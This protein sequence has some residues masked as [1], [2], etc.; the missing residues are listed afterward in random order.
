MFLVV[1]EKERQLAQ[2][3]YSIKWNK[4]RNTCL[5]TMSLWGPYVQ[6]TSRRLKLQ[7]YEHRQ[8]KANYTQILTFYDIA[9]GDVRNFF[10]SEPDKGCSE[11][12][13][14]RFKIWHVTRIAYIHIS[15]LS[16][17]DNDRN[18]REWTIPCSPPFPFYFQTFYY[19][20]YAVLFKSRWIF[21]TKCS[22]DV[23]RIVLLSLTSGV[24][25]RKTS[26]QGDA[27][28]VR[29]G[30]RVPPN[31]SMHPKVHNWRKS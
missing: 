28:S 3:W 7:V 17:T 25:W 8:P 6:V 30:E 29:D 4:I 9:A 16:V 18:E 21:V 11:V 12:Y 24:C 10:V 20:H 14:N 5:M 13:H 2:V 15:V 31:R 1:Q 23:C 26:N 22:F 19:Y 27:G